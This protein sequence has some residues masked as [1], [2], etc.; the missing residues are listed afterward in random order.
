[1]TK[2]L[3]IGLNTSHPAI[4]DYKGKSYLFYHSAALPNG[5]DKRR[6]VCVE[7]FSYNED[8]SIPE[9]KITD[10]GIVKAVVKLNPFTKNE[11]ET[12][13]WESGVETQICSEGGMNVCEIEDGTT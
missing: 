7:Q 5:S 12:I 3:Q 13:A 10:T 2:P 9:I 1:M 11:A 6:S 8:G 4:I